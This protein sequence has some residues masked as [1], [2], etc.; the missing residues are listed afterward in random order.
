MAS[1]DKLPIVIIRERWFWR[2]YILDG[3]VLRRDSLFRIFWQDTCGL[4]DMVFKLLT[5]RLGIWLVRHGAVKCENCQHL[6][7]TKREN[8][9]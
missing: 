5:F 7:L 8:W 1:L 4:A 3:K 6:V 2:E 9:F